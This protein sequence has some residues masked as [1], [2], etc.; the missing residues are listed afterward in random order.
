MVGE[1]FKRNNPAYDFEVVYNKDN[2]VKSAVRIDCINSL[3][4]TA[5]EG[6]RANVVGQKDGMFLRDVWQRLIVMNANSEY[7]GLVGNWSGDDEAK[8]KGIKYVITGKCDSA[9]VKVVV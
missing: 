2:V 1:Q 7:P 6:I 4:L 9:L 8:E 3:Q 5:L